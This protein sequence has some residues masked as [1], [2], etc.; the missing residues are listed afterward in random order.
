[1]L[2]CFRDST[3]SSRFSVSK[4]AHD[5]VATRLRELRGDARREPLEV[6]DDEEQLTPVLGGERRDDE[7]LL[8]AAAARRDEPLLLEAVQGGPHRRAA[9]TRAARRRRA[10]RCGRRAAVGPRRSAPAA[11]RRPAT[12]CRSGRSTPSS[13]GARLVAAAP[14]GASGT[15]ALCAQC[16]TP[17]RPRNR[18]RRRPRIVAARSHAGRDTSVDRGVEFG[19]PNRSTQAGSAR[20]T[21]AVP[22]YGGL[23]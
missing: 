20:S 3:P 1:M 6:A 17:P 7:A 11:R 13:D 5:L 19:I 15:Q 14:V 8:G 23:C 12:R 18:A 10:R 16:I 21:I 2:V 4:P 9:Q 22:M